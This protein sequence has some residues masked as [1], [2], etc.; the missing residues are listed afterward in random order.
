MYLYIPAQRCVNMHG[1][2]EMEIQCQTYRSP[3]TTSTHV[4]MYMHLPKFEKPSLFPSTINMCL[5]RWQLESTWSANES[6]NKHRRGHNNF[7]VWWQFGWMVSVHT[8]PFWKTC[9]CKK[10]RGKHIIIVII[11]M[12]SWSSSSSTTSLSSSTTS[13]SSTTT[14][15]SSSSSSSSSSPSSSSPSSSS[16]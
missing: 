14:S 1:C 11:V 16:W 12:S 3:W 7:R 9:S 15:L 13:L 2:N 8:S 6:G 10:K 4:S 5:N